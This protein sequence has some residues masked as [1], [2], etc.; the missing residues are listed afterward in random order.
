MPIMRFLCVSCGLSFR[1][2]TNQ[3]T[4]SCECGSTAQV[5]FESHISVGFSST[6]SGA[7][8]QDSGIESVD[9]NFDRVIGEDAR[10]KWDDIYRR[11]SDKWDLIN[12]NKSSGITGYD[13]LR[14]DDGS[15]MI[16]PNA[17]AV[18][19]EHRNHAMDIITE[20]HHSTKENRN[21]N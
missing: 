12:E 19:R 18:L 3:N 5:E 13:L 20:Q 10:Q 2:R 1:K 9:L 6:V 4:A 16:N 14:N 15:Y 11:R 8:A 7:V 21:G 17:G